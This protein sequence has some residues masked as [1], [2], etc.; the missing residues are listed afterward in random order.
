MCI[1]GAGGPST[2]PPTFTLPLAR[3]SSPADVQG[4][5]AGATTGG[6]TGGGGFIIEPDL[7]PA[8]ECDVWT[9]DCGPGEK[10]TAWANNG[11]T[12]WNATKCVPVDPNPVGPGETC[13]AQGG[14]ASGVDNCE[15]GSMCWRVDPQTEEGVCVP[16]CTCSPNTPVCTDTTTTC[17]ITNEGV[18]NLCLPLCDP[19]DDPPC[20]DG[21]VCIPSPNGDGFVCV[22]DASA[23]VKV[24]DPCTYANACPHG[25]I[26]VDSSLLADCFDVACCSPVCDLDAPAGCPGAGETCQP[27]F[28][29]GQAPM[30][31]EDAGLC[32]LP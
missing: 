11:G 30:C 29:P 31:L 3:K 13:V 15:K 10:C 22:V 12:S 32:R 20:A 26:C 8:I 7:P 14:G 16:L 5:L 28:P 18:L 9:Q 24:G 4:P 17:V 27:F 6:S 1:Q 21:D 19:L 23:G 2:P 25:S